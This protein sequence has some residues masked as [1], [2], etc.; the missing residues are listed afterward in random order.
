M[1]TRKKSGLPSRVPIGGRLRPLRSFPEPQT[2]GLGRRKSSSRIQHIEF[3]SKSVMKALKKGGWNGLPPEVQ[4]DRTFDPSY[5]LDALLDML[6]PPAAAS[7]PVGIDHPAF[8]E[9]NRSI[10]N[11]ISAEQ[12]LQNE[13]LPAV[14]FYM[15]EKETEQHPPQFKADLARFGDALQAFLPKIP[16]PDSVIAVALKKAWTNS[17]NEDDLD[18]GLDWDTRFGFIQSNLALVQDVVQRVRGD[19]WGKG[20]DADRPAHALIKSLA[21]V[22]ERFTGNEPTRGY[23]FT[24]SRPSSPFFSF[25]TAINKIIPAEFRLAGIDHLIRSYLKQ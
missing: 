18:P 17:H 6:S 14:Q 22:F 24:A 11:E 10:F 5:M 23:D 13:I 16:S 4:R 3:A 8:D 12:C 7:S 21:I 2:V 20:R 19:E 25:V 9:I 1:P 15:F